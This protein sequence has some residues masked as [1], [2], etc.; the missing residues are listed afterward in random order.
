MLQS[1]LIAPEVEMQREEAKMKHQNM[2]ASKSGYLHLTSH[3]VAT[4]S[5]S[6][7]AASAEESNSQIIYK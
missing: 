1:V 6:M 7:A 4:C 2:S 5:D 3:S